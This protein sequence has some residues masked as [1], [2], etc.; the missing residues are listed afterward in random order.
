MKL[1]GAQQLHPK[2]RKIKKP[3]KSIRRGY[4]ENPKHLKRNF[5]AHFLSRKQTNLS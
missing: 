5:N 3:S 4:Q 2:F 1:I